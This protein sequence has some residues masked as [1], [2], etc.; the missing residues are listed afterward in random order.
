[1]SE[2]QDLMTEATDLG[3]E[4][5]GNIS[6]IALKKL[7]QDFP[8][9]P[10]PVVEAAPPSPAVKAEPEIPEI[11]ERGSARDIVMA[12][13]KRR[14]A[15]IAAAK[16]RAFETRIVTLT[17]KDV[18]ENS[19]VSTAYLAFEN[20]YFG[21]A[22]NVPLDVP[23]ELERSLIEIASGCKIPLHRDEMD[24]NGR[25]TGNK[26]TVSVPKYVISY[27]TQKPEK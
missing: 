15:I 11:P 2:R 26:I 21:L 3:I 13:K 16:K 19:V 25:R 23:V 18:R 5:K 24:K 8:T 4:F 22:K 14:R 12:K 9:E 27:S 17:N 10:A 1:M 7:I 6:N 20:Q